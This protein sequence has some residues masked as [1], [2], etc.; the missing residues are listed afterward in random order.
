MVR[1]FDEST[2]LTE[3]SGGTKRSRPQSSLDYKPDRRS[4]P[5]QIV[6]GADSKQESSSSSSSSAEDETPVFPEKR[7]FLTRA[8]GA[9]GIPKAPPYS[10]EQLLHAMQQQQQAEDG[11]TT[12]GTASSSKTTKPRRSPS[13]LPEDQRLDMLK[14][15]GFPYHQWIITVLLL[16]F[17]FYKLYVNVKPQPGSSKKKGGGA[18][19]SSRKQSMNAT[20]SDDEIAAELADVVAGSKTSAGNNKKAPKK[21]KR[22]SRPARSVASKVAS[23]E[24]VAPPTNLLKARIPTR[25]KSESSHEEDNV[26][27]GAWTT[28]EVKTNTTAK[29]ASSPTDAAKEDNGDDKTVHHSNKSPRKK[30]ALGSDSALTPPV[31]IISKE[32]SVAEAQFKDEKNGVDDDEENKKEVYAFVVDKEIATTGSVME[33]LKTNGETPVEQPK[34]NGESA[35]S[36]KNGKKPKKKKKNAAVVSSTS[37]PVAASAI[38]SDAELALQL[39]QEE[40]L[41]AAVQ[42]VRE[43]DAAAAV[44][45]TEEWEEV[46]TKKKKPTSGKDAV[47]AVEGGTEAEASTT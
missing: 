14:E 3:G 41:A 36:K 32:H 13:L 28:V 24:A 43:N 4:N 44:D 42:Q 35:A 19:H 15:Q 21:K 46:M 40:H 31:P 20:K 25:A 33:E 18:K 30:A 6:V 29:T 38:M 16:G 26:D 2:P 23:V 11:T 37:D 8:R 12:A 9:S 1:L 45:A 39:Q 17:G 27:D 10:E 47:T 7:K 5:S 22:E 34:I